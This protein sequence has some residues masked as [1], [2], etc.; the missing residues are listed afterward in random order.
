M[1]VQRKKTETDGHVWRCSDKNCR[2]RCSI[3]ANSFF[4]KSKVP[5]ITWLHVIYL[6]SVEESN[7]RIMEMTELSHTTV[8][9]MLAALRSVC[10]NKL[11]ANPI[12]L[13][14]QGRTVETDKSLFGHKQK[15]H[16][17]RVAKAPWV[18]G[19][20]E[21]GSGRVVFFRVPNRQRPTIY[22]IIQRHV[23]PG[24]TIYSDD[25]STYRTLNQHGF[26]HLT[27]NH[28]E[29]FVDPHTG[30]HT[31]TIEGAWSCVKR[32]FKAMN[33]TRYDRLPSYLDQFMWFRQEK[34]RNDIFTSMVEDIAAGH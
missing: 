2:K 3:R 11:V 7:K 15:Y 9:K 28:S 1:I 19:M 33:G 12:T 32:K 27:V 18:F 20:I 25:F 24:T 26:I 10:S 6:W 17:G 29:N 13:G 31:N 30:V 34:W 23:L 21:R 14:G 22:P 16:R 8:V 4:Q 5:L